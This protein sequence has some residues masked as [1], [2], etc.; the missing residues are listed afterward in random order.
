[1][2]LERR[3]RASAPTSR[4]DVFEVLT[5][6]GSVTARNHLGGTAPDQVAEAAQ[7]ARTAVQARKAY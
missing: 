5:L 4:E 7:R 3:C 6:E 2:T 1:M